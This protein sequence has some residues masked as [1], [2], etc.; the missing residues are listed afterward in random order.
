MN[1]LEQSRVTSGEE[2]L[3]DNSRL[4]L[5]TYAELARVTGIAEGTLKN[6]VYRKQIPHVKLGRSVRFQPEEIAAWLKE[7]SVACVS[8]PKR[9][10]RAVARS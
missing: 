6:L 4:A 5:M 3:F 9:L 2:R 7:R 10:A 8:R 1:D